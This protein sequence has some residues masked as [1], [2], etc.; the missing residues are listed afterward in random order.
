MPVL[1]P[2]AQE[3]SPVESAAGVLVSHVAVPAP[4]AGEVD[5]SQCEELL[6]LSFARVNQIVDRSRY[7]HHSRHAR[8]RAH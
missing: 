6:A 3:I 1:A 2:Q 7:A 5:G 4:V 8:K